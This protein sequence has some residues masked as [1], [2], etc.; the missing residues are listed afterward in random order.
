MTMLIWHNCAANM[1][2]SEDVGFLAEGLSEDII[3]NLAQTG[4]L[5]VASRSAS[6]QSTERGVD[7]TEAFRF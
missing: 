2:S 6:F 7:L 4:G 1:T 3:D 5:K